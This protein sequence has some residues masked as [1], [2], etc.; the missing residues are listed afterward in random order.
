MEVVRTGIIGLGCRGSFLLDTIL[1]CE[2]AKVVALCDAYKDRLEKSFNT[3]KEKQGGEVKTYT[4]YKELLADENVDAVIIASSW[5]E[6][7]RMAIDSMKAGK[8]TA[9]EVGGAYDLEECWELVRTY[10]ITKTPFMMLENCC[11]GKFELL[12]TSLQRAG[13]LGE[14]LHCHGAYRHD[15]RSEILGG[16][17]NRHYRLNNYEKRC[18]ENYPTHE[19]GPI[20]KLLDINRGNR[21]LTLSSFASKSIGLKEFSNSEKNP[22]KSLAG[23]CFKQ[24]DIVNTVITCANG[25]TITLTLNTTLPTYYSREFEVHATKGLCKQEENIIALES[26][27]DLEEFWEPEKFV[28]KNINN[29]ENYIEYLPSYWKKI[30]EKEKDLGHGG[31]DFYTL[32]TFFDCIV[33]G[34]DMPID[35]YDTATWSCI[36]VLSEQSIAMGGA[37]QS[38]PDFTHGK[39]IKR[40]RKDVLDFPNV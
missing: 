27:C 20:A 16:N 17:V 14:I 12:V 35:V 32:K 31:M 22:D 2:K 39:W 9:M 8:I 33:N 40:K 26:D 1:V 38:F 3:V 23:K 37:V 21:M 24:A 10:E 36:T 13:K 11:F 4:D 30:N 29:A 7:I 34:E 18:A 6:H 19:I 28:Q 15:L 5:D 25:E